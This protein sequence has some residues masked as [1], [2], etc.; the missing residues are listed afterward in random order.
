MLFVKRNE[1]Y[2]LMQIHCVELCLAYGVDYFVRGQ[3]P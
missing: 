2:L 3:M 1:V